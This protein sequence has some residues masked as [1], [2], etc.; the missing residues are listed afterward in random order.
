METVAF[1][2]ATH[3]SLIATTPILDQ[4]NERNATILDDRGCLAALSVGIP[5]MLPHDAVEHALR[6]RARAVA[7]RCVHGR[8]AGTAPEIG[9]SR[10]HGRGLEAV[11]P[12]VD[13]AG[14]PHRLRTIGATAGFP[15][16]RGMR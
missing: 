11:R 2:M 16:A 4:S 9:P 13:S 15:P 10:A 8:I 12:D 5:Q 1:E 14:A 6:R 7:G 3:V